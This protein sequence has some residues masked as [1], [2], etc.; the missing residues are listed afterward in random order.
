VF[1]G[2]VVILCRDLRFSHG[3]YNDSVSKYI[4]TPIK[5]AQIPDRAYDKHTRAGRRR[6]RVLEHFF[7]EAASVRNERF[8]NDWEMAGRNAYFL[9]DEEGLG[10]A[11][12]LI[13]AV[14]EKR[15]V[16]FALETI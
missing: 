2:S 7:N 11:A 1:A 14:E 6:G 8:S 13:D 9:A 12:K 10:K 15:K 5:K 4:S 16:P 3:E